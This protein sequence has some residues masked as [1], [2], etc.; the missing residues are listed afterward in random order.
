MGTDPAGPWTS[1]CRLRSRV[2]LVPK[3]E[4]TF[5][6]AQDGHPRCGFLRRLGRGHPPVNDNVTSGSAVM[7][8]EFE[9]LGSLS[10]A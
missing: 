10:D 2:S 5:D 3:S 4:G 7:R 9:F 1:S 8:S 6:F